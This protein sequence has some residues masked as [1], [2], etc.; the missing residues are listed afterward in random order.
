V[1]VTV[2]VTVVVKSC[3]LVTETMS[4]SHTISCTTPERV[5]HCVLKMLPWSFVGVAVVNAVVWVTAAIGGVNPV[6]TAGGAAIT[7]G[8]PISPS[9][10]DGRIESERDAVGAV[11]TDVVA[12]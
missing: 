7:P 8:W 1:G 5:T 3:V 2:V 4:S 10:G 9:E 6:S 12:L 11:A